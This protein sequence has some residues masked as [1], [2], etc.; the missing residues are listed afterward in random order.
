VTLKLGGY[1]D[2]TGDPQANVKLSQ[3]RTETVM[4][5]L[6]RLG[7]DAGRLKAEGYGQEHPVADNSTEEGVCKGMIA[8]CIEW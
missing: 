1:T 8:Q 3:M 7:V 4:T 6:V 2:N 5:E